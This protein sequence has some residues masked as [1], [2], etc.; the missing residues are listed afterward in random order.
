M[1]GEFAPGSAIG[2]LVSGAAPESTILCDLDFHLGEVTASTPSNTLARG[3]AHNITLHCA[4]GLFDL[5]ASDIVCPKRKRTLAFAPKVF[6]QCMDT[7]RN[8]V[9]PCFLNGCG[10]MLWDIS[11]ISH[12]VMIFNER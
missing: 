9:H 1:K 4:T 2:S 3:G 7:S 8:I 5:K 10:A 11:L 12:G 6:F